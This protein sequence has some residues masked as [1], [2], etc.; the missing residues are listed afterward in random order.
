MDQQRVFPTFT[1]VR[2]TSEAPGYAPAASPTATPQ[3]FTVASQPEPHRPDQEFP[4][5]PRHMG[6]HRIPGHIHRVRPGEC[7]GGVTT[8]VSRVYLL[9]L[10]TAPDPSDSP[11][12][13]RLRRGC[14]HHSRRLPVRLPPAS[15]HCCDS[16]ALDGLSPP[17]G[18][19]QR[20]VAHVCDTHGRRGTPLRS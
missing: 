7:S 20:L 17:A 11:E 14:S 3:P 8:P 5:Y 6:A 16:R 13:T 19:H 1:D 15:P 4:I 18:Q 9:G 12:P 10:L 2:S